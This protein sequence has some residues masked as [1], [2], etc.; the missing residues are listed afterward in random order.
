MSL[1]CNNIGTV[2]KVDTNC[3]Y[4]RNWDIS[5]RYF[6][7]QSGG[8]VG[9]TVVVGKVVG[10]LVGGAVVGGKV[11]VVTTMEQWYYLFEVKKIFC[12]G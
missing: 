7:L 5:Y 2:H 6:C 3:K 9:S 11:V 8:S 10:G 12:N 4:N 1:K